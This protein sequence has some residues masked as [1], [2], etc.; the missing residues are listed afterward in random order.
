MT[1]EEV[2][3]AAQLILAVDRGERSVDELELKL[4]QM[5]FGDTS[6]VLF[7]VKIIEGKPYGFM[8]DN[9]DSEM[10]SRARSVAECLGAVGTSVETDGRMTNIRFDPPSRQ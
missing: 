7:A 1:D 3:E 10:I 8:T 9:P 4:G 2:V 5:S 6:A